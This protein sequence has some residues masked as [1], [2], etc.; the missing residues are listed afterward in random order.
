VTQN[1]VANG[2]TYT[3]PFN[4]VGQAPING[5]DTI[6]ILSGRSIILSVIFG[7]SPKR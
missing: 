1:I 3:D 2:T 5:Q 4:T 7:L 6:S